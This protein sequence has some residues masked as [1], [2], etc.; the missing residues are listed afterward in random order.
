MLLQYDQFYRKYANR[1]E[2]NLIV[3]RIFPL[4]ELTI[5]KD[6]VIHYLP[7]TFSDVGPSQQDPLFKGVTRIMNSYYIEDLATKEGNPRTVNTVYQAEIR[8]YHTENKRIRRAFTL[9]TVLKDPESPLIVN[10]CY[11]ERKI[12][13]MV[14]PKM[15]WYKENNRLYTVVKTMGDIYK[16]NQNRHQFIYL[17][18]P[19]SIPNLPAFMS[20]NNNETIAVIN[21]FNS[22][23]KIVVL[24]LVNLILD[25]GAR[26]AFAELPKR[27]LKQ[28]NIVFFDSGYF[29]IINLGNIVE[30][31][32]SVDNP[33]GKN[34]KVMR[35]YIL[36][37][38]LSLMKV[39]S[40]DIEELIERG[41]EVN[42]SNKTDSEIFKHHVSDPSEVLEK[43]EGISD[44]DTK[45]ID[46]HIEEDTDDDDY[47][48]TEIKK[49]KV[50]INTTLQDKSLTDNKDLADSIDV[51]IKF[52]SKQDKFVYDSNILTEKEQRE[53][54][55]LESQLNDEL[56]IV[57]E[58]K[59][60]TEEVVPV[61]ES[62]IY[63]ES[64]L[65]P[66]EAIQE[67]LDDLIEAGNISP[68]DY[69][70]FQELAE[71][72]K[73]IPSPNNQGTLE[74]Y[75]DI[76]EEDT[77]VDPVPIDN[78]DQ[79]KDISDENMLESRLIDFDKNYTTKLLQRD[80][81]SMVV[82][83][84]RGGVLV[85]NYKTEETE[86]SSGTFTNYE[87]SIQP[88]KGKKS[89]LKFKLPK[90]T[91]EG[92]YTSNGIE[93][94]LRRQKTDLPIRKI[95]SIRVALTSSYGK[96]FVER[97]E[98]KA[99]NYSKWLCNNIRAASL[100][101]DN[102][103]IVDSR[104]GNV[105]DPEIK[106][107][108]YLYTTLAKEFRTFTANN[109]FFYLDYHKRIKRLGGEAVLL[110]EKNGEYIACGLVPNDNKQD[111][112]LMD[113]HNDLY[114]YNNGVYTK[115]DSVEDICG[116]D[117]DKAPIPIC[118]IGIMGRTIPVGIV[119]AY[120][121]GFSQL[122][123]L[124]GVEYTIITDYRGHK[125]SS[126]EYAITFKDSKYVFKKKDRLA[127]LILYGFNDFK[128]EIREF[129]QRY[130]EGKDVYFN[131]LDDKRIADRY[132]KEIDLLFNMFVDPITLRILK[133]MQMPTTFRGLLFK[134]V[135]M[136]MTDDHPDEVSAY[137][138]RIRGYE[139]MSSLVYT[140][141]VRAI[142]AHNNK[143]V[144]HLSSIT[145]NPQDILLKFLNDP[146]NVPVNGLNPFQNIRQ[147]ESVT[148]T[149]LGGRSKDTMVK[150]TR[151]FHRGDIGVISEASVDSGDVGINMYLTANPQIT[152][153]YG[154]TKPLTSEV[155]A[156]NVNAS[157]MLSTVAN[158][159]PC[160]DRDDP[161]RA[162]FSS[163]HADA[164]VC[165][166][167]YESLPVRTGYDNIIPYKV[168]PLFATM[169]KEDGV[170]TSI[171]PVEIV[172][173]YNQSKEVKRIPLG[174]LYGS[175][176]GLT[177]PHMLK[178]DLKVGDKFKKGEA[179]SYNSGYFTRDPINP[180]AITTKI[181]TLATVAILENNYTLED[182]SAI[183][184]KF[185]EKL[186]MYQ[187]KVRVVRVKFDQAIHNLVKPGQ[188]VNSDDPLCL[189]EDAVTSKSSL[190][191]K[192][193]IDLLR[194]LSAKA[195]KAKKKGKI[196]KIEAF[197]NG[198][199]KDMS[200]SLQEIVSWSDRL[201]KETSKVKGGKG[202]TGKVHGN[203]LVEGNRIEENEVVLKIYVTGIESHSVGD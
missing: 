201:M 107:L 134:S 93:Y 146:A 189:I 22:F 108:P 66:D 182:G 169:A 159:M 177:V 57:K 98:K 15:S 192:K 149:G 105:F 124:L 89:T 119:L 77:K 125:V 163:I 130:F 141:M 3:P 38:L 88:I 19:N 99:F 1:R 37:F 175:D 83:I 39:R 79:I 176:G 23:S 86:D 81:A 150:R 145:I 97:S 87:V 85:T 138:Q 129:N 155:E 171:S 73:K 162:S 139:R 202:Y 28:I 157:A 76:I 24:H 47:T 123:R 120:K 65:S 13:Y 80:I 122:L 154:I 114:S 102:T 193:S 36:R 55:L 111:L 143:S 33:N 4:E 62:T 31:T 94:R 132:L 100:D 131:I 186:S 41:E 170:V 104:T 26:N 50:D 168:G 61:R 137:E 40:E 173:T 51:S 142:R 35:G 43:E 16:E 25:A 167:G 20:I 195:P 116:L 14:N 45:K 172:V 106:G 92:T 151:K 118:E 191:D 30:W 194:Q 144:K 27:A 185:A 135:E 78:D 11:M 190:F 10:Y 32:K 103:R 49:H 64:D 136:L 147:I 74:S 12:K 60:R 2:A 70:K 34:P 96:V 95:S 72:Y 46:T 153:Y 161:K 110:A 5:P 6:S 63:V 127:S 140:E 121:L 166:T 164:N 54:D 198:D 174:R 180:K 183:S 82:N 196:E 160:L 115:L 90:I 188:D 184:A 109:I 84:Q 67:Q 9:D 69:R 59:E 181:G 52:D 152:N 158:T 68:N 133:D 58:I 113:K 101:K 48:E 71:S 91:E 179:I 148:Y 200:E 156:G 8:R 18:N 7:S 21:K 42:N 203:Y 187:T 126:D 197:Y 44:K 29:S 56:S 128:N 75:I 199:I 178:T 112:L 117:P 17:E 53:L 165:C